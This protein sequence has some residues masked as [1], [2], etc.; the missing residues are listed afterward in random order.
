MV[1]RLLLS[2]RGQMM[3]LA[4]FLLLA[5]MLFVFGVVG[6]SAGFGDRT[7]IAGA[8]DAGVRAAAAEA[9]PYVRLAVTLH[10]VSCI[11]NAQ[12]QPT[13]TDGPAQT[14]DVAGFWEDLFGGGSGLPGW[15][16]RAGCD[17]VGQ[18][19]ENDGDLVCTDWRLSAWGWQYPPGSDPAGTAV[20]WLQ[21]NTSKMTASGKTTVQVLDVSAS[22]D[23][24][25]RV[26]M[27]GRVTEPWN[28]LSVVL[29]HPV[30]VTVASNGYPVLDHPLAT[31]G[32]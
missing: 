4:L 11:S 9:E 26:F 28:P 25:G 18:D 16:G 19:T 2:E 32:S 14:A 27:R 22:D 3:P 23:G 13:C 31:S 29:G 10:P 1:R 8:V 5:F 17:A 21:R 15:A 7:Q 12:P 24:T 6:V 30:T 20:W